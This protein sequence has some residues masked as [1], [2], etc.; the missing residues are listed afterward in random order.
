MPGLLLQSGGFQE[1]P[2]RKQGF[3]GRF[4]H[5]V[6]ADRNVDQLHGFAAGPG[7]DNQ[8]LRGFG[9]GH[10]VLRAQHKQ[11]R[12]GD[13]RDRGLAIGITVRP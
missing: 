8:R 10:L 2:H 9:L 11:Y 6:M 13:L 7:L 5:L 4:C 12:A 1:I 3:L